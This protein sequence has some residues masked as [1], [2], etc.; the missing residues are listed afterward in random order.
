MDFNHKFKWYKK[1]TPKT[2]PK[3]ALLSFENLKDRRT[4]YSVKNSFAD[5]NFEWRGPHEICSWFVLTT[6]K[7]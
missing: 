5:Y 2:E 4:L 7:N 1:S 6:N 3:Q